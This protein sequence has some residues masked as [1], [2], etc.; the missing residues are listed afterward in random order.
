MNFPVSGLSRTARRGSRRSRPGAPAPEGALRRRQCSTPG[1]SSSSPRQEGSGGR[2]GRG[3]RSATSAAPAAQPSRPRSPVRANLLRPPPGP[4]FFQP[5]GRGRLPKL[6]SGSPQRRIGF[7]VR[8]M[9][10][11]EIERVQRVLIL[12]LVALIG[13]RV[14][15]AF[16]PGPRSSAKAAA[17]HQLGPA[18]AGLDAE[19]S[20]QTKRKKGRGPERA[21]APCASPG[22]C[23]LQPSALGFY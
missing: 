18:A 1:R 4:G 3:P 9:G 15:R 19:T 2:R 11:N 7:Y 22:A 20:M 12:L 6:Q 10:R 14:G 13:F 16:P 5:V 8:V 23:L 17:L 21:G